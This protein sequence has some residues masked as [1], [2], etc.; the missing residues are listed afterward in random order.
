VPHRVVLF[1]L[2]RVARKNMRPERSFKKERKKER[3]RERERRK[4]KE[5]RTFTL[6]L[7]VSRCVYSTVK[8]AGVY[9][10]RAPVRKVMR[11][12]AIGGVAIAQSDIFRN[13]FS[14]RNFLPS[15]A[16]HFT[17]YASPLSHAPASAA[18]PRKREGRMRSRFS[19]GDVLEPLSEPL[20]LHCGINPASFNRA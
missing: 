14:P 17:F 4:R 6:R 15:S 16:Q 5:K 1:L 12:R 11:P 18:R 19:L 2:A 13:Y 20:N 9:C 8:R 7:P 3:Q 10:A